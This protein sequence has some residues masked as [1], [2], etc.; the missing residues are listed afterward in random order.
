MSIASDILA[1][2]IL[3]THLS[4]DEIREF[5]AAEI[6]R[7]AFFSAR[8]AEADYLRRLREICAEVAEGRMD[9]ATARKYLRAKLDETGYDP[10]ASG[11]EGIR[12]LASRRRLDL[13][14]DTQRKMAHSA[15]LVAAETPESLDQFPAWR[16]ERYG[17]RNVPRQDWT[18]RWTAAGESVGWEGA[19]KS[20]M[21]ALKSSPIWQAL[22]DGA[23]GFRDTLGNPYPPFAYG[24]GL[25]WSP[26]G[27][28][29]AAGLG[30]YADGKAPPKPA[31]TPGRKE[32]A[33]TLQRLGP[34][35]AEGLMAELEDA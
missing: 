9:N 3:P 24:S 13:I 22:G 18:A 2:A 28:D 23:G 17:S 6:R 27:R 32:I 10:D 31:L 25:D 1:K 8:T 12:N 29:E 4:S 14:L 35:F 16:L 30:L 33:D 34:D 11:D 5:W 15:A 21:V 19:S 20:Q 26:V 7:R